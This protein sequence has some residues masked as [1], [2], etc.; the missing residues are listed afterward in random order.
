M[1]GPWSL[2][3]VL[4]AVACAPPALAARTHLHRDVESYATALCLGG[5][6]PSLPK[7]QA[8]GWGSNIVQRGRGHTAIFTGLGTAVK[9]AMARTPMPMA[10]DE[11]RPM[12]SIPLPVQ[13]CVELVDEPSLR[14][15]LDRADAR[16]TPAYRRRC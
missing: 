2:L 16:L 1:R 9:A 11:T 12:T 14:R 8:D 4:G 5:R 6:S 3:V 10:P 7:E 13:Y 15:A